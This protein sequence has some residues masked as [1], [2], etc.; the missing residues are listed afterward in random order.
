MTWYWL[1][2][3]VGGSPVTVNPSS[4]AKPLPSGDDGSTFAGM[5]VT[6]IFRIEL[7]ALDEL[8][9]TDAFAA[10]RDDGIGDGKLGDGN[11]KLRRGQAQQ[12]LVRVGGYFANVGHGIH[13]ARGSA[14]V[15]R[16]VGVTE[17]ERDGFRAHAQFFGN[18]CA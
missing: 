5:P 11:T 13:K 3:L 14:A 9:V 7:L 1:T 15:R 18:A 2:G 16:P 12:R 10:A 4:P 17:D 8:A 6:G